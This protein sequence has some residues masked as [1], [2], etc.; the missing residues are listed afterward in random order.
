[1]DGQAPG[2]RGKAEP[3]SLDRLDPHADPRP[4]H[5]A[6]ASSPRA[7]VPTPDL[8][9]D[10]QRGAPRGAFGGWRWWGYALLALVVAAIA[11]VLG[12][13]MR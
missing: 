9:V 13:T 12:L 2:T 7:A 3:A 6:P 5:R 10:P 8:S 4:T 1:M 11:V